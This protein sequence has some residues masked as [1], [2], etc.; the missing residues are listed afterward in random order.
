MLLQ[1]AFDKPEHLAL[2]PQVKPFADIIEIG[3]PVLK[4]FG[5]S[6]ITTARA[7]YVA[8]AAY[9]AAAAG[10]DCAPCAANCAAPGLRVGD[11]AR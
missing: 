9:R 11:P 2:L 5:I 8:W 4:R 10:A 3:T 1:I 7:R 6:A